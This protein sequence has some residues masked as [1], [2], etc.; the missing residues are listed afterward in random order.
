MFP[1]NPQ[2]LYPMNNNKSTVYK[3]NTS[4]PVVTEMIYF[5]FKDITG[6]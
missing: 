6:K 4:N 5:Y 3:K 2:H 1:R